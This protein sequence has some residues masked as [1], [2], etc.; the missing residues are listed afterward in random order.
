MLQ[1][2][3]RLWADDGVVNRDGWGTAAKDAKGVIFNFA[4]HLRDALT[5][6]CL[7]FDWGRNYSRQGRQGRKRFQMCERRKVRMSECRFEVGSSGRAVSP[8]PPRWANKVGG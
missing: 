4:P 2:K 8:R 1:F 5:R 3:K 6:G 7:I